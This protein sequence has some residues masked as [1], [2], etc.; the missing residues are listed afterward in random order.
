MPR[1]RVVRGEP[2]IREADGS[3]A[4]NTGTVGSPHAETVGSPHRRHRGATGTAIIDGRIFFEEFNPALERSNG[5][6]AWGKQGVFE[7]MR[8]TDGHVNRSLTIRHNPILSAKWAVV[9]PKRLTNDPLAKEIADFVSWN[10]FE[11]NPW[12]S[13]LSQALNYEHLGFY[14]FEVMEGDVMAPVERFPNL[15]RVEIEDGKTHSI[16]WTSFEARQP[17]TIERWFPQKQNPTKLASI[18]QFIGHTDRFVS[19]LFGQF[20][21]V[22]FRKVSARNLLRFTRSQEGSNFEGISVIRPVYK[23]WKILE[24]LER[25]E[26]VRHERQNVGIPVITLPEDN[27]R[28]GDEAKAQQLLANLTGQGKSFIVLPPGWEFSWETSGSGSGTNTAALMQILKRDIMDNVHAGFMTLGNKDTG[29]YALADT[30]ED[31][32]AMGYVLIGRFIEMVFNQGLDDTS[33]I[34]RLVDFNYPGVTFYPEL[35]ALNL[36]SR[37]LQKILKAMNE[38]VQSGALLKGAKVD[39][40]AREVLDIEAEDPAAAA[41]DTPAPV[42]TVTEPVTP[43][44]PA[45]E[46]TNE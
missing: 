35:K 32:F 1:S 6:G 33:H 3:I 46:L 9:P 22:G 45:E 10:L 18:Q 38:S 19:G 24:Q 13:I 31:H 28:E 40:F 4:P 15:P 44:T 21:H 8:R 17:S 30:Q 20:N 41:V 26:A 43:V 25:L 7:K 11:R 37:D 39:E 29:S 2:V 12:Q 14:L 23:Y 36:T 27:Q 5:Y 34:Q 16:G 42:T